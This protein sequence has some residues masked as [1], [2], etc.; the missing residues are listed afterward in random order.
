MQGDG[1][2][3]WDSVHGSLIARWNSGHGSADKRICHV[4]SLFAVQWWKGRKNNLL[5]KEIFRSHHSQSRK[6]EK[7]NLL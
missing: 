3:H 5:K 7:E 6:I 4:T 1:R 2:G